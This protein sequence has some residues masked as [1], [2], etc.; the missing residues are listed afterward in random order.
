VGGSLNDTSGSSSGVF[1]G[2]L[3]KISGNWSGILSGVQNEIVS[4][5]S[6]IIGGRINTIETGVISSIINSSD[7]TIDNGNT[8]V[9]SPALVLNSH[10]SNIT[11]NF[12]LNINDVG[13]INT[14][15]ASVLIGTAG[16]TATS[17]SEIVLNKFS[18]NYTPVNESAFDASDRLL[19]LG[20]GIF[21]NNSDALTILKNGQTGIDID[22]FEDNTTG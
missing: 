20:K 8:N 21:N 1:S 6:T 19:T 7:S 17:F 10:D 15:N 22:N 16:V 5:Y 3:N 11:G 2:F 12:S 14:G 18:T 13:S 9:N 4:D